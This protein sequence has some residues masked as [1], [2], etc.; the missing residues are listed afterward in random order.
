MQKRYKFT[1]DLEY[2]LQVVFKVDTDKFKPEDA[3][4]LLN[5]YS[6][7][8]DQDEDPINELLKKYAI[9]LLILTSGS[10]F[11]LYTVRNMFERQEGFISLDGSQGVE[12]VSVLGHE[13]DESLLDM[14]IEIL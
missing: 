10:K 4:T 13:Y 12:L 1:Y 2:E 6:W 8:Y 9:E 7:D 3:K 5:F 11:N 14:E